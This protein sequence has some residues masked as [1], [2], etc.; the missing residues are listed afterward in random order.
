M[1][2]DKEEAEG[3]QSGR[4]KHL[5]WFVYHR[6]LWKGHQKA[7]FL[8]FLQ[9]SQCVLGTQSL[10]SCVNNYTLKFQCCNT[11]KQQALLPPR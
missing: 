11:K 8:S 10:L 4:K 1:Q 5:Q 3:S 6:A 9:I 7:H 2:P